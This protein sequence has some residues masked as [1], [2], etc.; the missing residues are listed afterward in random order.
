VFIG[1]SPKLV[2]WK[3]LQAQRLLRT[4]WFA[5][6]LT[7]PAPHKEVGDSGYH[8]LGT[9]IN[10]DFPSFSVIVTNPKEVPDFEEWGI[11]RIANQTLKG[12]EPE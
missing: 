10:P 4:M 2:E 5:H 8:N 9:T 1:M 7:L 3:S 11:S 12:W 6:T